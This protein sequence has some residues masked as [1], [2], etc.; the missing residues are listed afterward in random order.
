MNAVFGNLTTNGLEETQDR[1]GGG[2]RP[3]ES[4]AYTGK[5]KLAYAG[6]AASSNAQSVTI[7][8]AHAGGE[9]RE[10]FWITNKE[11]KNYYE[12]DGKKNALPGFSIVDDLCV[13]TTNK[14]LAQQGAED[15]VVN[16]YDFDQKKEVPT[17]VPMLVELIG[18]EVTFG[19]RKELRN[20]QAKDGNGVYQD[21]AEEREEN[22]TDKIFHYPS[23]L[24]VVEAKK[25]I[26]TPTFYGAWVER[27]KEQTRDRRTI[28]DGAG[29]SQNGRA[30][31]PMGAPPKAD[32]SAAKATSLFGA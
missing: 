20:K 22:V 8:L 1:L 24:T 21:T 5:I 31:R 26:Q 25:G 32:D 12:R 9:Y 4:G 7:V 6:K 10:T 18:K 15:K 14:G 13:V 17:S 30:G 16:L 2:F 27:N 11:G 3:L 19:I 23:N 28:K 29:G